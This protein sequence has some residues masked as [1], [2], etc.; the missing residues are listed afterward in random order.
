MDDRMHVLEMLESGEISVA[1]AVQRLEKSAVDP[2][3]DPVPLALPPWVR[4]LWHLVFWPG[5]TLLI[6]GGL[7][8]AH[9]YAGPGATGSLV[10]GW[11][12]FALGVPV[13]ALGAWLQS[14]H[15]FSVRIREHGR[16]RVTMAFPLPL[17]PLA[18]LLRVLGPF[19]PQLRD[20]GADEVLLALRDELQRGRP[21]IVDVNKDGREQVQVYF[22]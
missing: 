21:F 18:W 22:A 2:T 1:E 8:L 16:R 4:R 9:H 14:A 12:L 3:C 10:A 15:W 17:R 7:L 19:V 11:M 20:T 5:V 6:G 13:T